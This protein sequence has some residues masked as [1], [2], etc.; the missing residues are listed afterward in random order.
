MFISDLSTSGARP[1]LEQM[2]R[3]AGERQRLLSHNIANLS[4]PNFQGKDLSVR[5]FQAQLAQA[6]DERRARTGGS[7]G[8]L[9]LPETNEVRQV[10]ETLEFDPKETQ[11]EVLF[12][13]RNNRDY[14]KL[15]QDLAENSLAFRTAS[16]LLRWHQGMIR[17]AISQRP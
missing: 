3:F 7:T 9:R 12:Q 11:G 8:E 14:I 4:T 1:V 17:A 6:V 13:D 15:M 2:M 10:G 16:D 5:E